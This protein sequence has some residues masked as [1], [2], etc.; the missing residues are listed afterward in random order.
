MGDVSGPLSTDKFQSNQVYQSDSF[1]VHGHDVH[2]GI[3]VFGNSG[4][5]FDVN[6]QY[7]E[8][9]NAGELFS[10]HT[11]SVDTAGR[12]FWEKLNTLP[13]GT[14]VYELYITPEKTETKSTVDNIKEGVKGEPPAEKQEPKNDD[15]PANDKP[16][17]ESIEEYSG[18]TFLE[19]VEHWNSSLFEDAHKGISSLKNELEGDVDENNWI[20]K[21][22][23]ASFLD[24]LET[25]MSFTEGI[26]PGL[27]DTRRFGEGIAKGTPEGVIEDFERALN[28]LPQG[29]IIRAVDRAIT[30]MHV[31][32][33]LNQGDY[34]AA[35]MT[36]GLG[37]GSLAGGKAAA[38][39]LRN[40]LGTE[41]PPEGKLIGKPDISTTQTIH[42]SEFLSGD[43]G[44]MIHPD[45]DFRPQKRI[46]S[47]NETTGHTRPDYYSNKYN[48]YI[49][50][51]RAKDLISE[52]WRAK[53]LSQA[54]N[55]FKHILTEN[56]NIP[57]KQWLVVDHRQKLVVDHRGIISREYVKD[58]PK[59]V[60]DIHKIYWG[61]KG[62][63]GNSVFDKIFIVTNDGIF[64]F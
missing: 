26:L 3:G 30:T 15:R 1:D 28:V 58:I 17:S 21:A 33:A 14:G 48:I 63:G 52:K 11:D 36:G 2:F 47:A 6:Y 61:P 62:F 38:K 31:V 32:E 22:I 34:K 57:P 13:S 59:Y 23:G 27:L 35:A 45:G 4:T 19:D 5:G 64:M 60:K 41:K 49:E 12:L 51:K 54:D 39:T 7:Y 40:R 16:Q 8:G 37:V 10:I 20:G 29:K 25:S 43:I 9:S 55:R 53:I 24:V 46:K 44:M 50:N 42:D 56:P 18:G